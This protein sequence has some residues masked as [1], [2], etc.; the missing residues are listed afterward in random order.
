M[1]RMFL[2]AIGSANHAVVQFVAKEILK[3][4]LKIISATVINASIVVGYSCLIAIY[5]EEYM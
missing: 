1:Y 3:R 4:N 2:K 5:I